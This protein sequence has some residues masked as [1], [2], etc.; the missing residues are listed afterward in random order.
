MKPPLRTLT[1]LLCISFS[2]FTT[3]GCS[4]NGEPHDTSPD[5]KS[6]P[7]AEKVDLPLDTYMLDEFKIFQLST[8]FNELTLTCMKEH[9][10]TT[11][12]LPKPPV[13]GVSK[14]NERRYG[15]TDGRLASRLGY[16][17]PKPTAETSSAE[18]ITLSEDEEF[19]LTGG[20]TKPGEVGR[21]GKNKEGKTVP[22]G[23]C[24]GEALKKLGY[25][26]TA[27]PGNPVSV[28][29]LDKESFAES[30]RTD[31]VRNVL[32]K[33]SACMRDAGYT[34]AAEAFSASNDR[35]FAGASVT[36]LE[37]EVATA[38]VRCKKSSRLTEVW[39]AEET[40]IQTSLIAR[41]QK[42]LQAVRKQRDTTLATI[43]KF[44]DPTS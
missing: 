10:N 9:G 16:R 24:A 30:L 18:R 22:P 43:S 19:T 44:P 1:S 40:R 37:R 23:G 28:Q 14:H 6:L 39:Q 35:R 34:Y 25:A 29:S 3:A 42:E 36:K 27:T 2:L 8:L 11:T 5:A 33:W 26:P 13:P 4:G 31:R 32:E 7:V 38:D 12:V 21:G 15:I 17:T 41:H 20:S